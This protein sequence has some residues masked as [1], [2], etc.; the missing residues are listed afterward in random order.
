MNIQEAIVVLK[1]HNQW[2]KGAETPMIE[3]KELSE[4][5]DAIVDYYHNKTEITR[6][7]VINHASNYKP[8]GRLLTMYKE[9][10]DFKSIELSY[11]D[12]GK[13][14]KVFLG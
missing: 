2:R 13:T 14:L 5:I 8:I 11:Q 10:E 4:A 7:E 6:F 3:P 9:M 1:L 12:S